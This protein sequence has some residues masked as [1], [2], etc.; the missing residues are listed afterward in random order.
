MAL[1]LS[2]LRARPITDLVADARELGVENAAALKKQELIFEIVRKRA[3]AAGARGSGVLETLPDGFGF[4][5][6]PD[7]NYLP[8]PDDVYVSPSQIRRFNLRTGDLIV[9]AVRAP[10]EGER[11]FALIKIEQVNG[12][13]P[14]AERDKLLFDNLSPTTPHRALHLGLAEPSL[15]LIDLLLPLGLG[16]RVLILAPPRSGRSSLLRELARAA[17]AQQ[18]EVTVLVLL[19]DERPEE[20]PVYAAALPGAEIISSSFD[21]PPARHV[22]VAEIVLERARRM[23]E[24]GRDVLLLVDSLSRLARAHNAVAPTGG[25]ELAGGVDLAAVQRARRFFAAGR[26]LQEGGSLSILATLLTET[27]HPVDALLQQEVEGAANA[28]LR[29]DARLAALDLWP[30]LDVR[31][32]FAR[33]AE[34][35]VGA[36][37][38]AAQRQLRAGLPADPIEALQAALQRTAGPLRSVSGG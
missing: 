29:L 8:G 32:S 35:L 25:R 18:P 27:G 4:L 31:H 15:S 13:S 1:D 37:Q 9:G 23:V 11:Y 22:Q 30:P 34:R 21:E 24:Q 14:E 36:E 33:G 12:R 17:M 26:A 6:A 10:K 28:E 38:A 5:R 19:V 2:E 16:Q 7:C 20:V 3:G